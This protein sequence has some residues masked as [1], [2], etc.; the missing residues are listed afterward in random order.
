MSTYTIHPIVVGTKVFDKGMMTYQHDYG[1]PYTIPI[2][3]WYL[4]GGDKKILVDTGEMHPVVS[5]D[6]E[7]AIG[8]KI[9][10]L[11]DGLAR[12][13][14][15][16]EDIDVVIHTH[17]HSDHCENDYKCTNARFYIT[18][19]AAKLLRRRRLEWLK[20]FETISDAIAEMEIVDLAVK[21]NKRVADLTSED[22]RSEAGT[23][24]VLKKRP[25]GARELARLVSQSLDEKLCRGTKSYKNTR[26]L[27][28]E[29]HHDDLML[30]Y[31]PYIVRNTREPRNVH[32]F[33]C[34]TSGFTKIFRKNGS[35]LTT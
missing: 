7:K 23:S 2:Y 25:E 31:L 33:A 4:E 27:H 34:L 20:Q 35:S 8:G 15:T 28:T 29:P 6:R 18:L 12:Y 32:Y 24:I 22:F 10:T 9:Y 30:G 11:E 5:E 26:F 17:L 16:P 19:G 1:T 3:A 13:S 14:I 21:R